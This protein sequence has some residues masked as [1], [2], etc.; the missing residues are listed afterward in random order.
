M[1]AES[2]NLYQKRRQERFRSAPIDGQALKVLI[3]AGLT[4]LRTNQEIVNA[5]NVYPVP[6]GDT[7]IN[8]EVDPK[9][10]QHHQC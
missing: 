9:L 1:N 6:D 4:W 2:Q 8:M 10:R 7:G 3:G 5:L